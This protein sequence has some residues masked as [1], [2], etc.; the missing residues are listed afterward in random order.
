VYE[1]VVVGCR[2]RPLLEESC[3]LRGDSLS[4]RAKKVLHA[5]L[6]EARNH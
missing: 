2:M 5:Q 3:D 6:R 1:I 4:N